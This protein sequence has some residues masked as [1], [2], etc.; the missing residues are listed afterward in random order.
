MSKNLNQRQQGF[1]LI[2]LII[3][4]AI[5]SILAS[6]ALPNYQRYTQRSK[7][8]EVIQSTSVHKAT[9]ETAIQSGR[10]TN[11]AAADHGTNGMPGA[12][13]PSGWV[14]SVTMVDGVITATGNAEVDNHT[15]TLTP[16][17]SIPITWTVGGS[18]V[19][20]VIC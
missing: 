19:A 1:T 15:Y 14:T 13:G 2:E 18:C 10:V 3:V 7:F 6:I 20:V 12:I 9:L 4:V 8:A 16:T 17:I 5:I 11:L